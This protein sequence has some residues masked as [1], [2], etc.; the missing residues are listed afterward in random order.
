MPGKIELFETIERITRLPVFRTLRTTQVDDIGLWNDRERRHVAGFRAYANPS[1]SIPP[2]VPYAG[3][4][5][6]KPA[7]SRR[8]ASGTTIPFE[9]LPRRHPPVPSDQI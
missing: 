2:G 3:G 1:R 9:T 8:A 7:A 6:F 4:A 5:W